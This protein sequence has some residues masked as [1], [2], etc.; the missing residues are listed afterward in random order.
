VFFAQKVLEKIMEQFG[1]E[2]T[3]GGTH[4]EL[5]V[6]I[7]GDHVFPK[8]YSMIRHSG[9]FESHRW[10]Q[11]NITPCDGATL[12]VQKLTSPRFIPEGDRYLRI[13]TSIRD[14]ECGFRI[15][16]T[17]D[18]WAVQTMNVKPTLET[19]E[20][21]LL[22]GLYSLARTNSATVEYT[23]CLERLHP[24]FKFL[25]GKQAR[26]LYFIER[27][28]NARVVPTDSINGRTTVPQHSALMARVQF[29]HKIPLPHSNFHVERD[30]NPYDDDE[31]DVKGIRKLEIEVQFL[32][33]F[34][35]MSGGA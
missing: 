35:T 10:G 30:D 1:L 3:F 21:V 34:T 5:T 16:A 11:L 9:M 22:A 7:T 4:A 25:E 12:H 13:V 14:F 33:N 19:S 27:G 2:V 26:V 18:E 28:P 8:L 20:G 24:T 29:K 32:S 15:P 31:P 6:D 17:G 23:T